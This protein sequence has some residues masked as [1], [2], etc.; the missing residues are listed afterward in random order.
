MDYLSDYMDIHIQHRPSWTLVLMNL[1][2]YCEDD[3]NDLYLQVRELSPE[4]IG[5]RGDWFRRVHMSE[6]EISSEKSLK[7]AYPFCPPEYLK[8]GRWTCASAIYTIFAITYKYITGAYP[9]LGHIPNEVLASEDTLKQYVIENQKGALDLSHIPPMMRGIF[10]MSLRLS[11]RCRY[12]RWADFSNGFFLLNEYY[13]ENDE[14]NSDHEKKNPYPAMVKLSD[15][16]GHMDG[17][18]HRDLGLILF[19]IIFQAYKNGTL[20]GKKL[21]YIS[22][23]DIYL[24][25]DWEKEVSQ[26]QIAEIKYPYIAYAYYLP[27]DLENETWDSSSLVFAL[28]SIIYRIYTGLLPYIDNPDEDLEELAF[29]PKVENFAGERK[30]P[31]FLDTV[32][33]EYHEFFRKGLSLDKDVR[34]PSIAALAQEL[35]KGAV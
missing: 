8:E 15:I 33:E 21:Q 4:Q 13:F 25:A 6:V 10:Y 20:D 31:L 1:F 11:E 7:Q 5:M 27:D 32:P 18:K 14:Y 29:N 26:V 24:N 30:Y 3:V 17:K 23:K 35:Y 16:L 9:F 19:N 34:Y 22:P 28:C 12:Q 2:D